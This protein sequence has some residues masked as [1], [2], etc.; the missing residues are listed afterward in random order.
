M[1][2]LNHLDARER[3]DAVTVAGDDEAAQRPVRRP[4]GLDRAG[5]RRRRL[6][7]SDDD[8]PSGRRRRQMRRH[9]DAGFGGFHGRLEH[10]PQ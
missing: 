7:R 10:T 2:C 1:A 4:V 8:G 9:T 6:A 3:P 5:H